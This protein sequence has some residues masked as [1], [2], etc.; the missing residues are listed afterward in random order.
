MWRNPEPRKFYDIIIVGGGG[1]GLE[2]HTILQKNM[3]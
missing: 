1:Q 2:L 3:V